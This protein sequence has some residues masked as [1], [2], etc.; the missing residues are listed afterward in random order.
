VIK[1]DGPHAID[2]TPKHPVLNMQKTYKPLVRCTCTQTNKYVHMGT[3]VSF[4][5]QSLQVSEDGAI[6]R[7]CH[8]NSIG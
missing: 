7:S 2:M 4:F 8:V 3:I 1:I 6:S 5:M